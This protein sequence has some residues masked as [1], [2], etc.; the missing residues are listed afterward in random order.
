MDEE[1]KNHTIAITSS[2]LAGREIDISVAENISIS[3]IDDEIQET[4]GENDH[5]NFP[6]LESISR[7]S[8]Q[9]NKNVDEI[10]LKI[11]DENGDKAHPGIENGFHIGISR[12]NSMELIPK[13]FEKSDDKSQ[14]MITGL[15][16]NF[17]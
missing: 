1:E 8:P 2:R 17:H 16:N 12:T 14:M 6:V 10:K 5:K 13:E 9:K 7:S 3:R 11:E 4:I 15:S